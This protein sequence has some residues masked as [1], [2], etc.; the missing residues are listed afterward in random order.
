MSPISVGNASS[1]KLLVAASSNGR[2]LVDG[3]GDPWLMIGDS[4]Q[5]LMVKCS[6]TEMATYLS[7]RAGY[8]IN[9]VQVHVIAGGT[10]YDGTPPGPFY[11]YDSVNPFLEDY[12]ITQPNE[13]YF[14]RMDTM[15]N[16]AARNGIVVMLN[17]GEYIDGGV[18][19]I[20]AGVTACYN[21]GM[22]L[23]LRYKKYPNVLWTI[24]ND[25]QDWSTNTNARNAQI[26]ILDGIRS[27][28]KYHLCTAWLDYQY[29][30]SRES[31]DFN[32]RIELDFGYTYFPNYSVIYASR[33]ETPAKPVFMAESNYEGES[34]IGYET[35]PFVI[36][37]QNW[38]SMLQGACG[39]VYCNEDIWKFLSGWSGRLDSYPGLTHTKLMKNFLSGYTWQN[40]SPDDAHAVLTT[41]YGTKVSGADGS[42]YS[43]DYAPCAWITDGS[44]ALIYMPT[45]RTMTVDMSKFKGLATCRWFDPTDGSYTTDAASPHANTGTH[46]FSRSASNSASGSDWVLV[47]EA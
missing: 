23:G 12:D 39:I 47:L 44:L 26:N 40:L 2:Y 29:S 35:T 41:G 13:T 21:W 3:A 28:D 22:Y 19:F 16:I 18:N 34:L 6:T 8:G 5:G 36:R 30:Y 31:S 38:W 25:F 37:K 11:T 10:F 17:A 32:S 14:A 20:N 4:P 43:N 33:A 42:I 45:N 7:N 46:D 15:L 1:A 9:M 24:G 27:V